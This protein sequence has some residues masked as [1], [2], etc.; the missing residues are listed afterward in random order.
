M[1]LQIL[2]DKYVNYTKMLLEFHA[3]ASIFKILN[4]SKA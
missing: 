2:V 1:F 3:Y 4:F